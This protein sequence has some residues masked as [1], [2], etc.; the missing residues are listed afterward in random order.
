MTGD[1]FSLG[2]ALLVIGAGV[3]VL[4]AILLLI[5]KSGFPL[6]QLP[7]DIHVRGERGSFY[8]PIVT[9]IVVS[10]IVTLFLHLFKR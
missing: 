6:G 9:S 5:E 10:L 3:A 7:G 1:G 8:F 2:K 4:G